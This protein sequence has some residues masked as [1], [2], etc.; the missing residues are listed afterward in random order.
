MLGI[1]ARSTIHVWHRPDC[2]EGV[3]NIVCDLCSCLLMP[4]NHLLEDLQP[5]HVHVYSMVDY[6]GTGAQH[7]SNAF[8]WQGMERSTVHLSM[9][10]LRT[11]IHPP[12]NVNMHSQACQVSKSYSNDKTV[13]DDTLGCS[14][15][16]IALVD[17]FYVAPTD[18]VCWH[19]IMQYLDKL[20][21][22]FPCQHLASPI[23]PANVQQLAVIL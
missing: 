18:L 13:I 15:T 16:Q 3:H 5:N 19:C 23:S 2:H 12:P 11:A 4:G 22:S 21:F 8:K 1:T 17:T 20:C 6:I 7:P 10:R 14:S 9:L